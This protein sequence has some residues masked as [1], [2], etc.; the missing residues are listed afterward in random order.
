MPLPFLQKTGKYYCESC[1]IGETSDLVSVVDALAFIRGTHITNIW[2]EF[3]RVT[4][5]N[6]NYCQTMQYK[7][8]NWYPIGPPYADPRRG[9]Q[10]DVSVDETNPIFYV[11][12]Q[13]FFSPPDYSNK[14]GSVTIGKGEE[15]TPGTL[16]GPSAGDGEGAWGYSSVQSPGSPADPT[17]HPQHEADT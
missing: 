17:D 7:T 4:I 8:G 16:V 5:C 14:T 2:R 11:I 1:A 13:I 6:G 12:Y 9:F 3:D 10:N 15:V